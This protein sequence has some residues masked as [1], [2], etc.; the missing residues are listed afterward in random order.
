MSR[1]IYAVDICRQ[2]KGG[3]GGEDCSGDK[4]GKGAESTPQSARDQAGKERGNSCNQ[5][6]K[7]EAG[8]TQVGGCGVGYQ[9]AERALGLG[10]AAPPDTGATH[11]R[12]THHI[13][14]VDERRTD[15]R[16]CGVA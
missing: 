9:F 16:V 3:S 4:G 12:R 11:G 7:S 15:V 1:L 10:S 5:I 14:A 6:E 8:S 13:A 2:T